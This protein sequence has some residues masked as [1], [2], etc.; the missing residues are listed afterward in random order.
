MASDF[1]FNLND[2]SDA[3]SVTSK[4]KS[5]FYPENQ[6]VIK[7]TSASADGEVGRSLMSRDPAKIIQGDGVYRNPAFALAGYEQNTKS[8]MH[9]ILSMGADI[10]DQ[11]S[12]PDPD[13]PTKSLKG[14]Q[15][16]MEI[17]RK[18]IMSTGF[19]PG[20]FERSMNAFVA[21]KVSLATGGE[22]TAAGAGTGSGSSTGTG[23]VTTS[24]GATQ[25]HSTASYGTSPSAP[26][27]NSSTRQ[28]AFAEEMDVKERVIYDQKVDQL[29]K[30]ANFKTEGSGDITVFRSGFKL[31]FNELG[32][33]NGVLSS[34]AR[35]NPQSLSNLGFDIYQSGYYVEK[36]GKYKFTKDKVTGLGSGEKQILMSPTLIEFLL[37]ITD[38]L[39]IMGDTG[40]WRGIMGPNFSKLTSSKTSV[41]DHSFGR[42]FDIKKIG[43]TT[44]NQTYSLNNPVPPPGKYLAALDIFLSHVEQL[45]Q[46]LHPDL[47]VV[48][49]DL[50][51]E[52]GIVEG[53]E[54]SNSAI[55]LKHPNL[56]PF[57]NIHCD[58]SHTNHIHV[59]WGSA[60]CGAFSIPATTAPATSG[61]SG[62]GNVSTASAAPPISA[63]MLT[64]LKTEYYTG[65]KEEDALTPSDIFKFLYNYGGFSAEISAIFAGIAVRESNC[66]PFVSNTGGAFGLWQFGTRVKDGG[67]GVV[68]IVSPTEERI[69]F[70]QLTYRDW[71]KEKLIDNNKSSPRYCDT[72]IRNKQKTD[73]EGINGLRKKK[74]GA[75][76]QYYDRR[77]FAPINQISFLR[78]KIG[79]K[80]DVS[81]MVDSMDNGTKNGIFAPW[82]SGYL[83]HSWISG[84]KYDVIKQVFTEGTGRNSS[85][86]D[87]WI[88]ASVPADSDA[89]KIDH[90]DANG[91]QKIEV[92]VQDSK[93]YE[94]IYK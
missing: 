54:S 88:L 55:R 15:A 92:F 89:R 93:I 7:N 27:L 21:S 62:S 20:G 61:S 1:N 25:P 17:A 72:F 37:R 6:Q 2:L 5:S 10:D 26:V 22:G 83:E 76:R 70:W 85:E 68:K 74:G 46:E 43:L 67:A 64:K 71:K 23:T 66:V 80:T 9:T 81:D 30:K 33:V 87:A 12:V 94:I 34:K 38:T 44:T 11:T 91:R 59:S 73:P 41:S 78:T 28:I 51:T 42:G 69:K 90:T 39:Y 53:L 60:R 82:G 4:I 45:P 32:K 47:I 31:S 79:H 56:A 48:S 18:S 63:D 14:S 36:N 29:L 52:L 49:S 8:A 16:R 84:L 40:V 86:L 75:G 19:A 57:T 65:L 50:E 3:K 77:A 35:E 13:D 58:K 24:T